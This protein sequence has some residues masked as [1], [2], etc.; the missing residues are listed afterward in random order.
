MVFNTLFALTTQDA[1]IRCFASV[2]EHLTP[3]GRFV[4]SGFVPDPVRLARRQYIDVR[5]VGV[6]SV[7]V[8]LS[9]YNPAA[10]TVSMMHL[11]I[12]GAGTHLYPVPM[13]YAYPSELDLM[14]RLAGLALRERWSSW[15]RGPFEETSE[16]HVSV[17]ERSA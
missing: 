8:N 1:Q 5:T 16:L 7:R 17:Y 12:D 9:R 3:G 15:T 11:V 2:A 14:A 6:D 13:R 10:Q 4:L